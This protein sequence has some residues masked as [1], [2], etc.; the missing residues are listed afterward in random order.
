MKS[1]QTKI[2]LFFVLLLLLVQSIALWTL[3]KGNNAQEQQEISNRLTTAKTIFTEQFNS[4]RDYL[5]AFAETAAKDYGIKDV[6]EDDTRSL[7]FA[8]NNHRKRINADLAMAISANGNITAQL[9]VSHL[10]NAKTKVQ[11]GSELGSQFKHTDWLESQ[12]KS[13]LY[14]LDGTL[15]QLSLS[16]LSVGTSTIGWLA[17]GFEINQTLATHFLEITRL[18]VDFILNQNNQWLLIA[19]SNPDADI[20]FAKNIV[21]GQTPEQY[22]AIGEL[23]TE[24]D[25]QQFGLAMYGLRADIVKLL[26]EQ[27]WQFLIL[28]FITLLLSLTSAYIIA[29]S[30]TKP[31]KRLVKQAKMIARGDYQQKI[32]LKDSSELG[33]LADE[34]NLMQQA[35]L[36]REQEI[37]HRANHDPLTELPNRNIL[38]KTLNQCI[39]NKTS[40]Q[41]FHLNLS[42]LKDV[43]E[44]LGHDVGDWLI[45]RTADRLKK[46][47]QFTLLCHLGGD[48]FILLF[49]KKEKHSITELVKNINT[50]LEAHCD[51]GGIN[52][53]LQ[54]RIGISSFPEHSNVDK[55]LLQMADTALQNARKNN[56]N[57]QCYDK[58][59]DVNSVERLNLINDL[60]HAISD[61]QLELHYQPKLDLK[62]NIVTH[63]EA[64][65]RWY[66]P[67]LGMIP[68]DS[69]IH[70][71]EQTGQIN[72]LTRW[73]VATAFSQS[74]TW[75]KDNIDI[76]VAVNISAENLKEP[77][78]YEFICNTLT[79]NKVPANKVT[80]EVTESAVVDNPE[81][82]IMLLQRFKDAG[83]KISIDDYGTGYSSLA[84]LKQLPVHELKIDKSF[85][86]HLHEDEDDR[87]IVR[88]TIELAHNMGL[89]VVSEGIEDDFALRWL[90]KQGCELGQGYF[91]SRPKPTDDFTAWIK[92][93]EVLSVEKG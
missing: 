65:V 18:E 17:F 93:Q 61:N 52:L 38:V 85:V 34:F 66:H 15:Y 9:Q 41:L 47:S 78:F 90:A 56:K 57:Y 69:F 92:K 79:A 37:T 45:Q 5:A 35:V 24:F 30:I 72:S 13:H 62:T 31:I 59:L 27:W 68:P 49:E 10:D 48:E 82:A 63:A 67:T 16:P 20:N 50:A 73:V 25:D 21:N 87:I 43:N 74:A 19:S 32:E 42:R 23:I 80:L 7:L 75:R 14:M 11:K 89:S 71:A 12:E 58:S 3:I 40:F 76:N 44:T 6:F 39:S 54:V 53:Q 36:T 70:I 1:L 64:L 60:K 91:I 22:I 4:R 88:S 83:I 33:Q 86:Q 55:T 84:Q 8:L 46:L 77:D 29:A 28:T 51:Y 81:S 2:F 26:Q